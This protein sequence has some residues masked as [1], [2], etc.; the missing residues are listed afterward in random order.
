MD[1]LS[2]YLLPQLPGV[3]VPASL[4]SGHKRTATAS[5]AVPRYAPALASAVMNGSR[6]PPQ[7]PQFEPSEMLNPIA[8]ALAKASAQQ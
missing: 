2:K 6:M 4:K 7:P 8:A 1:D 5:P 3:A